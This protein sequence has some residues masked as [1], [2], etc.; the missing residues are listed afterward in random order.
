MA[1]APCTPAAPD[2]HDA[3]VGLVLVVRSGRTAWHFAAPLLK[4]PVEGMHAELSDLR[5]V[6]SQ[7]LESRS[8]R[9]AG[10]W[11]WVN[12][13]AIGVIA[14]QLLERNFCIL[15]GLC[16]AALCHELLREVKA[17]EAEGKLQ[18]GT[19]RG[20]FESPK[21]R[22]DQM[23]WLSTA[24][25]WPFEQWTRRVDTLVSELKSRVP[26]LAGISERSQAHCAKYDVGA[27]YVR[28]CDNTC[29]HGHGA[30]CN[31]RRLTAVY[32]LNTE[33][34]C[35]D[36]GELRLWPPAL[37]ELDESDSEPRATGAERTDPSQSQ[38]LADVQPIGDRVVIFFADSRV[39]HEV[40]PSHSERFAL[41]L[42]Y[43][44]GDEKQRSRLRQDAAQS[45]VLLG[46][47]R[48]V[49]P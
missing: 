33:W 11:W 22:G 24:T 49:N 8:G 1:A 2:V 23:G 36:G 14:A 32:Y 34:A 12:D 7:L 9:E 42:W 37:D 19:L 25:S 35:G 18:T 41:T 5:D 6:C 20:G 45:P 43:E 40:L 39:P 48:P 26:G 4:P 44:D 13:A 46:E 15:D 30:N 16:G 21:A 47:I 29:D 17:C 31:G 38:P 28:H 3:R 27:R 10:L